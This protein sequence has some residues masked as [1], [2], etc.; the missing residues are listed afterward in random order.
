MNRMIVAACAALLALPLVTLAPRAIA[1]APAVQV[2]K[3][4]KP[5]HISK[6]TEVNLKDYL[7]PGKTTVFDF[8]S[9]YCPPCVQISP[10]LEKLHRTRDDIAVVKVDINRPGVKTIDWGSPVSRQYKLRSVPHFKIYGPNGKL[11]AEDLTP[12]APAR[13]MVLS[14]LQ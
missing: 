12:Q 10:A 8:Y 13:R 6:G 3:G 9:D 2:T 11:L 7:V 5:L 1:A 4:E 14:W